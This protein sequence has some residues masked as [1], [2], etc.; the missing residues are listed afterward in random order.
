[1]DRTRQVRAHSQDRAG[2]GK[3]KCKYNTYIRNHQHKPEEVKQTKTDD[4]LK[5]ESS[6][7]TL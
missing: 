7:E 5:K 6:A 3:M 2:I 1:M 4:W